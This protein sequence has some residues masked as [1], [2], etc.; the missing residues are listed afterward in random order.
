MGRKEAK[1]PLCNVM[2]YLFHSN[3]VFLRYIYTY[4]LHNLGFYDYVK[5][6]ICP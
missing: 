2:F 5:P 4:I 6:R 1:I 3:G